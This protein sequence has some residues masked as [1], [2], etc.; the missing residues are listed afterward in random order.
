MPRFQ[1]L[2]PFIQE[3]QSYKTTLP[4]LRVGG[5]LGNSSF[6][7]DTKFTVLQ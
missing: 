2:S 7:Y 6:P 1:E 4:I 5:K 3:V